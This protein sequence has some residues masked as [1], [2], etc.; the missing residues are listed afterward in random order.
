MKHIMVNIGHKKN[1]V[2]GSAAS[3]VR[4]AVGSFVVCCTLLGAM[5]GACAGP[6]EHDG[7]ERAVQ[8]KEEV[9]AQREAIHAER[10]AERQQNAGPAGAAPQQRGPD[11]RA[12]DPR[13]FEARAEEQRRAMQDASRNAETG[14][15]MRLTADERRD[16][17]RQINEAGQDI[18]AYPP[19]H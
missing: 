1:H 6:G 11:Q 9:H 17:R 3:G 5:A 8:R 10:V 4:S 2:T 7:G 18:Y 16:L 15:R 12:P 14:R 13:S 19:R